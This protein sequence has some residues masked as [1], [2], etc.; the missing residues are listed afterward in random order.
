MSENS[1]N[2]K[3]FPPGWNDPPKVGYTEST[4][5]SSPNPT[6][7]NLNK[8]VAFP[9]NNQ[10]SGAGIQQKVELAP[11][12]LPM[13]FAKVSSKM[14]PPRSIPSLDQNISYTAPPPCSPSSR[15]KDEN[16][17][18][19]T[20]KIKTTN[21]ITSQTKMQ[22]TLQSLET[23]AR[24]IE[25]KK[26]MDEVLRRMD[27]LRVQLIKDQLSELIKSH[28]VKICMALEEENYNEANQLHRSLMIEFHSECSSWGSSLRNIILAAQPQR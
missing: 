28:L 16:P 9:M 17:E 25:D 12:G 19:T 23:F 27:L 4:S 2:Q 20:E 22:E 11:S 6:K 18:D 10:G 21:I 13:P 15:D 24:K 3:N 1:N 26:V 14:E 7:L 8:R 5:S